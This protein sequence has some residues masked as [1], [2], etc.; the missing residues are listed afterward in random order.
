[1]VARAQC[2]GA[3]AR[4]AGRARDPAR[5]RGPARYRAPSHGPFR[6]PRRRASASHSRVFATRSSA[7]RSS[8]RRPRARAPGHAR[9]SART[10]FR[11]RTGAG[12]S[13][14][15]ASRRCAS[16]SSSPVCRARAR[17][18]CTSCSR[19]IRRNRV[20][21]SW[22]ARYCCPPPDEA[23]HDS[24][25]R[26]RRAHRELTLWH[27]LVPAYKTMHEMG[28][29][30]PV[31]CGDITMNAFLGDR[32]TALHQVPGYAA[33]AGTQDM[34]PVYAF[35]RKMLQHPAVALRRERWVL[36]APAHMNWL[37]RAD[38]RVSG[39]LHRADAP[40]SAAGDGLGREP[41]LGDPV[42][43]LGRRR[44]GDL[45]ALRS[46]ARLRRLSSRARCASATPA[47]ARRSS[48]TCATRDLMRDPVGD[49]RRRLRSGLELLHA[50][51]TSAHPQLPGAKPKG[52][53]GAHRYSFAAPAAISPPSARR[54]ARLPGALR[55]A[56]GV[57]EPGA[58]RRAEGGTGRWRRARWR[59]PTRRATRERLLSGRAW[60]EFCDRLRSS[61][62]YVLA[63]GAPDTPLDRAEGFRYL[64]TLTSAGI[65]HA[66]DLADPDR[67]RFLRNPDSTSK[68]G[69]E[70]ADNLYLLAKIRSDRSY[71]I[72]GRRNSAYA[73]LVELK[74]GY[75]QLGDPPQLRDARGERPRARA[76]RQLRDRALA[77]SASRATGCRCTRTPRRC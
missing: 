4:R 61:A 21:L 71:R 67:P 44:P 28:G 50:A 10:A 9:R 62:R 15:S 1:M 73:F 76:R 24:D 56:V 63:P 27:A 13:R 47:R 57:C 36:K 65:R 31:E 38:R 34:R 25:P 40:R 75:M 59:P 70:N 48:A 16:R 68:W 55:R 77:R 52:K 35:H 22:E 29:R 64:A 20:P 53:L 26:I 23:S 41:A 5:C 30:I 58:Q 32:F 60:S 11:W 33:W 39:C 72:V 66:F 17:R 69:A 7:R 3:R 49:D 2:R 12:A 51:G 37:P 43:A 18:S 74:E 46:A 54:F 8:T 14:R 6:F 42:D 19:R 45:Q